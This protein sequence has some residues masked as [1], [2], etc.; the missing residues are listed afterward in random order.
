MKLASFTKS[1]AKGGQ[2]FVTRRL[3][4]FVFIA[5]KTPGR[6]LR[7]NYKYTILKLNYSHFLNNYFLAVKGN[8]HFSLLFRNPHFLN[9]CG[10]DRDPVR[11]PSA[12]GRPAGSVKYYLCCFFLHFYTYL[13]KLSCVFHFHF[14]NARLFLPF[15]LITFNLRAV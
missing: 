8:I 13:K 4:Y 2:G 15:R 6:V 5:A 10:R 1:S 12:S 14:V 7:G 11:Y 9:P 3:L